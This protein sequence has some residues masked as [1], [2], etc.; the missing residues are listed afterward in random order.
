[1]RL[2][3][4]LCKSTEL[5]RI[6]ATQCIELG[7]VSVNDKVITEARFQVH[8]N[9]S[10]VWQ[11]RRLVARPS[12]YIM[13]HKPVDTLSSNVDG[14]YPS[15]FRCIDVDRA[16]DLHIV[17]RLDADTSGLVLLTDDGRWS[18]EIIRPEKQCPKTYRVTLR[19]A[20]GDDVA[21]K[22][23]VGVQ[24]QNESQLTAAAHLKVV[25]ENE[26]LL[27]ITEGK[28]HQVKRM[29]AA[30]GNRVNGLHR[31]QIGSLQLDVELAQ[32]RYLTPDEVAKFL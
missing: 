31:E 24:L 16:E 29:F 8:E 3:K 1:M 19:D 14:D 7:E 6:A 22:F 13:L 28:Y 2:D 27:T 15:L 26:V 9:N 23:L 4:F 11:G 30:V 12:R 18:F 10:V 32:W 25:T 17:G 20:I 5:T 21:A